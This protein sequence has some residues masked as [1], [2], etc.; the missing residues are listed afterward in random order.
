VRTPT[1]DVKFGFASPVAVRPNCVSAFG[2]VAAPLLEPLEVPPLDP[3]ELPLL[4]PLDVPVS[5][6]PLPLLDP[7]PELPPDEDDVLS[8][9]PPSVGSPLFEL[10]KQPAL[11]RSK[12]I[13]TSRFSKLTRPW[14]SSI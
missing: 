5:L 7:D 14:S 8:G 1:P 3:P 2:Q 10:E 9:D 6:E 11:A 12:A 13:G 4:A